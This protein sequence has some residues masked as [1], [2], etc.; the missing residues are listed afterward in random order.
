MRQGHK[1]WQWKT[2][3]IHLYDS[4]MTWILADIIFMCTA[5]KP[6]QR[7][8]EWMG[9]N[10]LYWDSIGLSWQVHVNELI[11]EYQSKTTFCVKNWEDW[12]R[13]KT[14]WQSVL[15]WITDVWDWGGVC[16]GMQQL[17]VSNI[18]HNTREL[19]YL[20]LWYEWEAVQVFS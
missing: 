2:C 8:W 15:Q 19:S 1:Y 12:M 20:Q 4:I 9:K 6:L 10:V 14:Q 13:K 16:M 17:K 7:S 3:I 18:F 5:W 11:I